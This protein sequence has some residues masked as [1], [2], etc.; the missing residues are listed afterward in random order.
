MAPEFGSRP[1]LGKEDVLQSLFYAKSHRR[2]DFYPAPRPQWWMLLPIEAVAFLARFIGLGSYHGL[3]YDEYYYV[4][5]AD[6]LL[7]RTPPVLVK[8]LVFG[9]D[10]NLLSAPPFA[11]EVIAASIWLF[12]NNPWA[13]RLPGALLG[14]LVPVAMYFFA[15]AIF[16]NRWVSLLAALL[17]AVDGLMVSTSRLALLDSIAFPFVVGNLLWL[18]I[19]WGRL[20]EGQKIPGKML[21]G[22][23]VSL[24]LGLSAKWIGA[25]TILMAWIILVWSWPHVR[26]S[27]SRWLLAGSVTVIPLVTYFL[28]YA[29]AFASG[30]HQSWLPRNVFLAWGK[31]QWLI[32]KNM[33]TLTFYHPWTA[34]AWTWL[35][36]PRPTAYLWIAH[37]HSTIRML[38]F[39][40]PLLIWLGLLGLVSMA[41]ADVTARRLRPATLFFAVWLVV[42]YGTWLLTPRS[43]FNYYFLSMMPM[44]I[45]AFSYSAVTLVQGRKLWER[46]S[47]IIAMAAV[48]VSTA[49]LFPLW[50][51][52]P[53]P[54]GFYHSV[55]WSSTWNAKPKPTAP[56]ITH[57]SPLATA[58]PLN[59]SQ[60]RPTVWS[61]FEGGGGHDTAFAW[62]ASQPLK[63]GYVLHLKGAVADQPAIAGNDAYVGTNGDT[64]VAWSLSTGKVLWT[65]AV[66]NMVMTTPLVTSR[67]V[68]IG[69]GNNAFRSFSRT[70][71]WMRGTGTNGIMAFS[72]ATGKELWYSPTV[73]EDMP[74]PILHGGLIY[75]VTGTGRLIALNAGSGHE[76]WSLPLGGFDS[77]SS[78]VLSGNMLYVATNVYMQAYPAARSTVWAVNLATRRIVWRRNVPV[79]SGLSDCSPMVAKGI[80][81][82]AGVP[83]I[84]NVSGGRTWLSNEIFAVNASTGRILWS[85][86]T[87]G[88]YLGLDQEEVGIPFAK[89]GR[90]FIGNPAAMN[91]RAYSADSGRLLWTLALPAG[92]TANPVQTGPVLWAALGNGTLLEVQASSGKIL[93]VDATGLGPIGPDA[94]VVLN[95]AVLLASLTGNVGMIPLVPVH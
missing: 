10:P 74:T 91:L 24:G 43:K 76:E 86:F 13:W 63:A 65:D 23:G 64:L 9:I 20:R 78:P 33:W 58:G 15:Q 54:T 38:A 79:S 11:K 89:H 40:N 16:S 4:T 53:M 67:T 14:S 30:F 3:I 77:M 70:R 34:N 92:L 44:L 8:H 28:T 71:G 83:R 49:Y 69:L 22:F 5:A 87:G 42:F 56:R 29:Y 18:W 36:L 32:L 68:F 1:R 84:V 61:A 82:I 35:G 37:T 80:L 93:A 41:A 48:A 6:V 60:P 12:G 46:W 72:R 27:R 21:W 26:R 31:L 17:A 7:H 51:G 52:M 85:R 95:S 45:M 55:F 59:L 50:V 94:P 39:S 90:V 81:Y 25:Q 2:T 66:P 62:P 19:L 47:G 88:G 75:E 73:G 57:V